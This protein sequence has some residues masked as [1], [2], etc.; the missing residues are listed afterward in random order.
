MHHRDLWKH[1]ERICL[2]QD[3]RM[4][5]SRKASISWNTG[6]WLSPVI[7]GLAAG[8]RSEYTPFSVWGISL[9]SFFVCQYTWRED[10]WG[11]RRRRHQGWELI[12]FYRYRWQ[13]WFFLM[14]RFFTDSWSIFGVE[15]SRSTQALSI[16]AF[17]LSSLSESE[18]SV[19]IE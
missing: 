18:H 11:V 19:E 5:D 10:R 4:Q 3:N 16:N 13:Y 1:R 15:K 9:L 17:A 8:G 6:M 2:I 12:R 14:V 7:K